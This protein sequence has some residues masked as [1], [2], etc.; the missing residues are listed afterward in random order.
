MENKTTLMKKLKGKQLG[1]NICFII[2][3]GITV[4]PFLLLLAISVSKESDIYAYGYRMIPKAIDF[5][6]YKYLSKN[7]YSIIQGYKV[8]ILFSVIGTILVTF[9]NALCAYPLSR[10]AYK[11][12]KAL[13]FYL[14][15]TMLFGGGLVPS[16]ILNAKWLHLNDSLLIYIVPGIIGAWTVFVFR[17]FI[18]SLPEEMY[19]SVV[20]D[21]GDEYCYFFRFVL[22]LIKPALATIA[23]TT[24][25]GKWNDWYTSLIYIERSDL[26]S[27][28]YYLQ[29]ILQNLE[30]LR[31]DPN[32]SQFLTADEVPGETVRM[33]MV[34]VAAGPALV[35]FPFF[36]KYFV[37]GMV[38][39]SVK[40]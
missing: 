26:R 6:A 11:Y 23:L 39:G 1:L 3:A 20:V 8:T 14:Y 18:Q 19:E 37:R 24:F 40:G 12:R 2:L 17:T 16:Y 35:I 15:F 38:V 29:E 22:P 10:K 9:F 34:V 30:L 32:N 36:Q 5:S 4:Y 31:N 27:L 7:S 33:A 13:S 21:G 28:Q 25:L